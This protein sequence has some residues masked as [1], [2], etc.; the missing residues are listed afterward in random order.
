MER[1]NC[2]YTACVYFGKELLC[3]SLAYFTC[4]YFPK[5]IPIDLREDAEEAR[6]I[7]DVHVLDNLPRRTWEVV[8]DLEDID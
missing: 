5:E 7:L 8:C 1:I 2:N 4:K 6:N 3:N